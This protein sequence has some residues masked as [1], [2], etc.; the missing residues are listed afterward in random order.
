MNEALARLARELRSL[1]DKTD[2]TTREIA[3][4]MGDDERISHTTIAKLLNG[5]TLPR[6]LPV[7]E[8]VRVLGGDRDVFEQLWAAAK[9][10]RSARRP[11]IELPGLGTEAPKMR[12]LP[13]T[14]PELQAVLE[15]IRE[16]LEKSR[17]QERKAREEYYDTYEERAEIDERIRR[18]EAELAA[19]QNDR[20]GLEKLIKSLTVDREALAKRIR[21]LEAEL[22]RLQARMLRLSA[23]ADEVNERRVECASK[24]ARDEEYRAILLERRLQAAQEALDASLRR[25]A[26]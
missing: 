13:W 21:D 16:R 18:L 17:E 3:R 26:G 15:D 4:R 20:T 23:E 8:V 10:D 14:A 19:E 9:R 22:G 7:L 24:W 12:E 11:L 2:M 6:L 25:T 5:Q 1:A